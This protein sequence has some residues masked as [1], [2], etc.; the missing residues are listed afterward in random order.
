MQGAN[1]TRTHPS[2]AKVNAV[3]ARELSKATRQDR[4]ERRRGVVP[5]LASSCAR[6]QA[7]TGRPT[8]VGTCFDVTLSFSV[9]SEAQKYEPSTLGEE[10]IDIVNLSSWRVQKS[11]K[12]EGK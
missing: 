9:T 1:I 10:I 11:A 3:N 4:R 7:Y 8:I 12:L 2:M 6:S 5:T